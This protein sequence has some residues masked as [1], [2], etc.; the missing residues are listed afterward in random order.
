[1]ALWNRYSIVH[2]SIYLRLCNVVYKNILHTAGS[3]KLHQRGSGRGPD[4][5]CIFGC[6]EHVVSSQCILPNRTSGKG[7]INM[8]SFGKSDMQTVQ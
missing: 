4:R 5:K 2:S 3:D 6:I 8:K 1:M 7:T